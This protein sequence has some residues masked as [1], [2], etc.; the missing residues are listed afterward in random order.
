MFLK[1]WVGGLRVSLCATGD[2]DFFAKRKFDVLAKIFFE[3]M[4]L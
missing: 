2:F 4:G 1:L 3:I